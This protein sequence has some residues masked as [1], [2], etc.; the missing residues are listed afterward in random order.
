MLER[1]K[2]R[3]QEAEPIQYDT[4]IQ[5]GI[6]EHRSNKE[7]LESLP[8][9][10]KYEDRQWTQGVSCTHKYMD[11]RNSR[12]PVDEWGSPSFTL[13]G[14]HEIL[15]PGHYM[16][17]HRHILEAIF[18]VVEGKGWEIH[19]GTRWE[20]EA[21]DV[22][23]VPSYCIHT[24]F[25][26]PV[27]GAR[28]FL[29]T[30]RLYEFM[31]C[32]GTEQ[33]EIHPGYRDLSP[34]EQKLMGADEDLQRIMSERMAYPSFTGDPNNT[35]DELRQQLSEEVQWRQA[36]THVVKGNQLPWEETPMG[37][38][39]YL[40][41]PKIPTGLLTYMAWLQELPPG[42]KSGV[43]RHMGE[44]LHMILSGKGYDLHDGK[45]WEWEKW[46][47]VYVPHN[48]VHQHVNADPYEPATFYSVQSRLFDF[49]GH[50]GIEH[51]EDAPSYKRR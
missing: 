10:I 46:D 31:G 12:V 2:V 25:S 51:M 23:C 4:R 7:I 44:E 33:L 39:K 20:W 6:R 14:H 37:R 50:G 27:E 1:E 8:H 19:D 38:I 47:V 40:V 18:Y 32:G 36:C 41:H 45:K 48:V 35:Y 11:S 43:H 3:E 21:G 16:G 26:D 9:V 49:I 17:T 29:S 5:E 15:R 22:M 30:Q 24:H 42:G 28:M 13:Q 34:E